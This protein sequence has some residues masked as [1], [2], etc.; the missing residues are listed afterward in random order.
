[1]LYSLAHEVRSRRRSWL[2]T[3]GQ[4]GPR[5]AR[6]GRCR[7]GLD[8]WRR[9]GLVRRR[10]DGSRTRRR[11]R[12]RGPDALAARGRAG[13]RPGR[14]PCSATTTCWRSAVRR[15]AGRRRARR[16]RRTSP[17][18]SFALSWLINGGQVA[19][20]GAADRGDGGV[21]APDL[22]AVVRLG[23][24]L[25][26]H[27]DTTEYLTWGDDLDA[28]NRAIADRAARR[29]PAAVVGA[30][31]LHDHAVRVPR[32][33]TGPARAREMLDALGGSRIV[34]GHSI[35]GDL[36]DIELGRR[37]RRPGRTPTGWPWRST[38]ASTT[39]ARASSYRSIP[40]D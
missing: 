32:H 34:H 12:G 31:A 36:R 1:M 29:R 5:R 3:R 13:R 37:S 11:G 16:T 39:A 9:G 19:R 21:A 35:I 22:P 38:A 10:P 4:G 27:A 20:P 23:S 7:R 26:L 6:P 8:R 28:V 18:R 24:D 25:L 30:L 17:P 14:R 40:L 33:A 2:P 15:F